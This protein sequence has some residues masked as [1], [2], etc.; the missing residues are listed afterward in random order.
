MHKHP[1]QNIK[2]SSVPKILF[3]RYFKST[4]QN[5]KYACFHADNDGDCVYYHVSVKQFP[6]TQAESLETII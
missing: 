4:K 1:T 6:R 5:W 2:C 3:A